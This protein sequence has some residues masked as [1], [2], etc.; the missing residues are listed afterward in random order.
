[1]LFNLEDELDLDLNTDSLAD[2]LESVVGQSPGVG[3]LAQP[4]PTEVGSSTLAQTSQES[5]T[6]H[7][8]VDNV[9]TFCT[10]S[11][12]IETRSNEIN[13]ENHSAEDDYNTNDDLDDGLGEDGFDVDD[14]ELDDELE[15]LFDE[16]DDEVEDIPEEIPEEEKQYKEDEVNLES[17]VDETAYAEINYPCLLLNGASTNEEVEFLRSFSTVEN[18]SKAIYLYCEA[19]QGVCEIGYIKLN[20]KFLLTL[21]RMPGYRLYSLYSSTSE[22]NE[23][24]LDDPEFLRNFISL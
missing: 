12:E 18:N 7:T 6:F 19:P 10:G 13:V 20:L 3:A 14:D 11:D 5:Q 15:K 23:I 24:K 1:M 16:V 9:K 22:R 17:I 21:S 2:S 8:E 4:S